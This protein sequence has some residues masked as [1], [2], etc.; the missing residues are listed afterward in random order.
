MKGHSEVAVSEL[1]PCDLC[2]AAGITRPAAYDA[3]MKGRTAWANMCQPHFE[4]HGVGLGLGKG[5]KL[6]VRP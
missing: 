2:A 4:V 3:K 1:P 5:Q 6:V